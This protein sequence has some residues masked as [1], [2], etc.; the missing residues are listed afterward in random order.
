MHIGSEFLQPT[1]R[2]MH[3]RPVQ[4]ASGADSGRPQQA[5]IKRGE[6]VRRAAELFDERGYHGTGLDDIAAAVG[7]REPTLYHYFSS[8]DEI[9]FWIH[10]DVINLITERHRDRARVPMSA[11]QQLLE[12][13][14]DVLELQETRPGHARTF[15]EHFRELSPEQQEVVQAKRE[16]YQRLLEDLLRRGVEAGEFRDVDVR[17]AALTILGA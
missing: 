8:K 5:Q 7:I 16:G 9:L 12:M 6:I 11:Q 4:D 17:L 15:F 3:L 2:T 13:V 1:G 14:S 10:E